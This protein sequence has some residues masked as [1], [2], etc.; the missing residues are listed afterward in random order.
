MVVVTGAT[1][2]IGQ[3]LLPILQLH[4]DVLVVSRD[5]RE[6]ER[7]FPGVSCC[8]YSD[9]REANLKQAVIVHLATANNHGNATSD[10]F[11]SVNVNF[12]LEIAELTRERGS[13]RFVNISSIRALERKEDDLYGLSKWEGAQRLQ[14]QWPDGVINVYL[15]SVYSTTFNGRLSFMNRLPVRLRSPVLSWLRLVKPVVSISRVA[16]ALLPIATSERIDSSNADR[17]HFVAD[18]ISDVSPYAFLKRLSDII[19][20]LIILVLLFPLLVCIVGLI[21]LDSGGPAIF[22]QHRVGRHGKLF[23]CYKFRTMRVGTADVA[24]HE[25]SAS[26]VT[27][28]GRLLRRLK[29]DELPQAI[30]VLRNE[31]SLVGPRPCLPVQVELCALRSKRGVLNVKPGITG[32]AQISGVDMSS[33]ARLAALDDQYCAFRSFVGD[34]RILIATAKGR[35]AGDP[36]GSDAR[37]ADGSS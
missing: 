26:E 9:L 27:R 1:G 30:N 16:N 15:P 29:L 11:R 33:P 35:G 8:E 19:G 14:Q 17:E 2:F 12:L 3:G 25:L 32:L 34:L 18:P 36:V 28:V 31:M 20:A 24:T 37:Q 10:H 22:S 4:S 21:R 5:C 23:T 6:A 7:L 13:I